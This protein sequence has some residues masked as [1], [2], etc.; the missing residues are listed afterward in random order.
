MG[1]ARRKNG[2]NISRNIIMK[3]LR[4]SRKL[5]LLSILTWW[6]I[7]VV[8]STVRFNP[9]QLLNI[10]GFL[11][12]VIVPGMLTVAA[13][14]IKGLQFWGYAGLIV[15]FSLFELMVVGLLGNT[16]LPYL[17]L[18]KPLGFW[19]LIAEISLLI[20]VLSMNA[21][22]GLLD[23]EI[24]IYEKIYKLFPSKLDTWLSLFPI[25]FVI[26]S[27]LGSIVLNNGGP[28]YLTLAMLGEI[29]VYIFVLIRYRDNIEENTILAGLFFSS[30]SLLLMTSL[31]GWY[32]TGHDIQIEYKVF[33][34]TKSG[35]IWNI[36]TCHDAYNAC[37][38][39]TI[40]PTIF[41]NLLKV[42]DPYIYK[43]FFQIFFAFCPGIIYL[44][45]RRWAGR[46]MSLFAA[47]FF[48]SFP[49]FFSD[50]PFLIR[51]EIA[52]LFYGLMLW[53]I[54]EP[55]L[56]LRNRQ[57][58]FMVMGI[59]VA[60]SHYSTTYIVLIIFGLTAIS[61]SIL[62][63]LLK[64]KK[65]FLKH[66]ARDI[67]YQDMV[68]RKRK[69]TLTMVII[70]IFINLL[71]TSV[72]TKTGSNFINVITGTFVEAK[73]GFFENSRSIDA[74][75][76]LTFRSASQQ[77]QLNDYVANVIEPIKKSASEGLYYDEDR[78]NKYPI[79]ALRDDV[80]PLTGLGKLLKQG[81][82]D[83]GLLLPLL[84][85]L[86][87]KILEVLIPI[88]MIYLFFNKSIIKDIDIEYYIIGLCYLIFVAL[89]IILPILSIEYGIYRAVQ[90]A[91][92]VVA[93][94]MV[95]GSV[96]LGKMIA[97][98]IRLFSKALL[99]KIFSISN[100]SHF[101]FVFSF[102]LVMIFFFQGTAF[103][104]QVFGGNVAMLHLNNT[105]RYYDNY[106]IRTAEIYGIKSL[107]NFINENHGTVNSS[108]P[109][110]QTERY[111]GNKFTILTNIEPYKDIFPAIIKKNGYAFVSKATITKNRATLKYDGDQI[112]YSYPAQFLNE[113]K[114][115]IY[116]NGVI[117]IFR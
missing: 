35:S 111:S 75:S 31:R 81:G 26:Q 112:I 32:I 50:M 102:A 14:K 92:F 34:L 2:S 91:M 4:I 10:V 43:F 37:M 97:R 66:S 25:V 33:Q 95:V 88:G 70:L 67:P 84:G 64:F 12:L 99:P 100:L 61:T 63:S 45:S 22:E 108:R 18:V 117:N 90:Q 105:G 116:D 62:F 36:E 1:Q 110:V 89:N 40:L 76:L 79:V 27:V 48:I 21:W 11:F 17:G 15:G 74:I 39:V 101:G 77:D 98:G 47:L 60:L 30:L 49:T 58:L 46:W 28:G 107:E 93:L 8:L 57:L 56:Q 19:V 13:L 80:L 6:I 5:F 38:S 103:I 72:V 42:S 53:I 52:F 23:W 3:D 44:V 16:L 104:P 59:G 82:V 106:L 71:W 87:A 78:Y 54:F 114:S 51:Q 83:V 41:S 29:G 24:N 113:N 109:S 7:F 65:I 55:S 85:Q 94:P 69:V 86:L 9:F 20:A 115:I 73:N 68:D 96:A